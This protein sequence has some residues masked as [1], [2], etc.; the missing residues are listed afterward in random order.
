MKI[1]KEDIEMVEKTFRRKVSGSWSNKKKKRF[2]C[3]S[4]SP[5]INLQSFLELSK[6]FGTTKIDVDDFRQTR[7]YPTC[8][9]GAKNNFS[10]S[11]EI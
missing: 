8:D 5:Q 2:S 11:V 7:G 1:T 3:S 10:V 6:Y 4:E 9:Y